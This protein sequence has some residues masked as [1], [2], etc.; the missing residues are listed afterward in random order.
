MYSTFV[1]VQYLYIYWVGLLRH[2]QAL[3][4]IDLLQ[5]ENATA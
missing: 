1:F 4:C 5:I 3:S 2:W